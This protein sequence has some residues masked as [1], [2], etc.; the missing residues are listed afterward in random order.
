MAEQGA[1]RVKLKFGTWRYEVAALVRA[2]S[3]LSRK[4]AGFAMLRGLVLRG[5]SARPG[6]RWQ[7]GFHEPRSTWVLL[8][9]T[10]IVPSASPDPQFRAPFFATAS[11][12]RSKRRRRN[13]AGYVLL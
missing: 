2:R 13:P 9:S 6:V 5:A 3:P 7:R 4:P 12:L 1:R 11:P 8:G 10:S